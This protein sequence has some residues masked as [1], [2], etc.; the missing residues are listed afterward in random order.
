MESRLA[1]ITNESESLPTDRLVEDL[2]TVF[3]RA[4]QKAV[5]RAKAAD[6]VVRMHPY[7]TIGLA[8]GLGL[9]AGFLIGRRWHS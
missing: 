6:R 2:K 5:E 3:H 1:G 9:V 7:Q 8:A 4:E